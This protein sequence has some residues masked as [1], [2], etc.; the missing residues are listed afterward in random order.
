MS[1]RASARDLS[2]GYVKINESELQKTGL[3]G[4]KLIV[5]ITCLVILWVLAVVTLI[6]STRA[7]HAPGM[8]DPDPTRYTFQCN[9]LLMVV[10]RMNHRGMQSLQ[11][12]RLRDEGYG[13]EHLVQFTGEQTDLGTI[14][15]NSGIMAGFKNQDFKLVAGKVPD[16][17]SL[18]VPCAM[19]RIV[20]GHSRIQRY[21]TTESHDCRR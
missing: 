18:R 8:A 20:S 12:I 9:I 13:D 17:L 14:V 7:M 16:S 10:L 11:F 19:A 15:I 6:V 5:V 1:S 4:K 2:A 21:R 3:R